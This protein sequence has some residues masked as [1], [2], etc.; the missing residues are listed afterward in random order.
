MSGWVALALVLAL[1]GALAA[2]PGLLLVAMITLI[3]GTLTRLWSRYGMRRVEYTRSLGAAR[4]VVGDEV[5]LDV[6]IWNRKP[7]PLPW[8]AVDDL[9]TDGLLIRE[10]PTLERSVCGER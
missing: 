5:A 6:T 1:V 7:L 4:A 10:R 8:V 9:V 2:V 3:Y